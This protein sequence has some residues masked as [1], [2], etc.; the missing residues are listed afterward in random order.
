MT[1]RRPLSHNAASNCSSRC[2]DLP[3]LHNRFRFE[4]AANAAEPG[5]AVDRSRALAVWML[6]RWREDRKAARNGDETMS[7]ALTSFTP[8]RADLN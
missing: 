5:A 7:A 4:V 6:E 3:L 1:S 8:T 2:K